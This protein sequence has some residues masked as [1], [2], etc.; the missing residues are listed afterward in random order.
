M[1]VNVDARLVGKVE[2]ELDVALRVRDAGLD[3]RRGPDRL[4]PMSPD[5]VLEQDVAEPRPVVVRRSEE[6]LLGESWRAE[7]IN[8]CG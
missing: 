8:H 6:R 5:G 3:V 2:D 7:P 4:D 1:E